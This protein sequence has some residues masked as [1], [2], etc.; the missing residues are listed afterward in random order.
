[1]PTKGPEYRRGSVPGGA[2]RQGSETFRAS[3]VVGMRDSWVIREGLSQVL[4]V[5][6]VLS[7]ALKKEVSNTLLQ[8]LFDQISVKRRLQGGFIK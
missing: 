5:P 4:K 8:P 6:K 3:P 2:V 7:S 1:M